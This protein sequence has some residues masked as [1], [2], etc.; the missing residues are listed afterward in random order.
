MAKVIKS[1]LLN[2]KKEYGVARRTVIEDGE[3][4][5]LR[6]RRFQRWKLCLL[7]TD[8]DMQEPLIW[9]HLREIKMLYLM[10]TNMSFR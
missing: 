5:V 3:A 1:D 8:S 7:W 6:K 4:A 9:L 2:I 10:R